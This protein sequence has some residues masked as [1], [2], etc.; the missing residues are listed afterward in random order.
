MDGILCITN[1]TTE[2]LVKT[3]L[4]CAKNQTQ[5][6]IFM[7]KPPKMWRAPRGLTWRTVRRSMLSHTRYLRKTE[8][9]SFSRALAESRN[10]NCIHINQ[11]QNLMQKEA[12]KGHAKS[13]CKWSQVVNPCSSKWLWTRMSKFL[14]LCSSNTSSWEMPHGHAVEPVFIKKG[15][16]VN[17]SLFLVSRRMTHWKSSL[18]SCFQLLIT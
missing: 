8:P 10:L 3:L 7:V 9:T 18:V 17:E 13:I 1:Q 11:I 4:D 5:I 12:S 14:F 6:K 16:L 15:R 2:M